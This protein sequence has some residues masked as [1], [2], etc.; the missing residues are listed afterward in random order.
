M[1]KRIRINRRYFSIKDC[2]EKILKRIWHCISAGISFEPFCAYWLRDKLALFYSL[3][4]FFIGLVMINK[5]KKNCPPP[6][7]PE[8]PL[9]E[10][11]SYFLLYLIAK[12]LAAPG[13][14]KNPSSRWDGINSLVQSIAGGNFQNGDFSCN[15]SPK[16]HRFLTEKH[17]QPI[18]SR[19][20]GF[21]IFPVN[22]SLSAYGFGYVARVAISLPKCPL[23]NKTL[24]NVKHYNTRIYCDSPTP[25]KDTASVFT[26][27]PY[28]ARISGFYQI[29]EFWQRTR[30]CANVGV[31]RR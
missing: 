12:Y 9:P 19:Q 11:V 16:N 15:F 24:D 8:S 31:T 28:G 21:G 23:N 3:V 27:T 29:V 10:S 18:A 30:Q 26:Q 13:T 6:R 4:P 17:A 22:F 5:Y 1:P 7:S 2:G 20:S 25:A 14:A